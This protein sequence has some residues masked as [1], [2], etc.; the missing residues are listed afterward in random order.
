MLPANQYQEA[1]ARTLIDKPT[2]P[3]TDN[4]MMI[5][6]SVIGLVGEAGELAGCVHWSIQIDEIAEEIGDQFWYIAALCTKAGINL[7]DVMGHNDSPP[8]PLPTDDESRSIIAAWYVVKVSAVTEYIKKSILHDHG[9][10]TVIFSELITETID[11]LLD[12]IATLDLSLDQI[13]ADNIAK[14]WARY[15]GGFTPQASIDRVD[16]QGGDHG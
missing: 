8:I 6:W 7:A 1:A 11:V 4:E 16:T 15:P 14:L 3:I 2:R 10:D 13:W 5:L 12:L 9:F